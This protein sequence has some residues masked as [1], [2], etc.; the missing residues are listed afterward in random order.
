MSITYCCREK[1]KLKTALVSFLNKVIV[2]KNITEVKHELELNNV[3]SH[4]I[5]EATIC[6]SSSPNKAKPTPEGSMQMANQTTTIK[7]DFACLISR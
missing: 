2:Q 6:E 4:V 1:T 5:I 7:Q 3:T